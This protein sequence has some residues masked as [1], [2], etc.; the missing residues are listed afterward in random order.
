MKRSSKA[1]VL[2]ASA[3]LVSQAAQAAFT[4]NDLYLGFTSSSASSDYIIDLGQPGVVG[5]GA[6]S[7]VDLS[8][9]FSLSMFN[10][11]FHSGPSGVSMGVVGGQN[12]FPSSYDLF[13]TALRVGGA[14]DRAIAGSDLSSFSHSQASIANAEVAVTGNPFPTAGNGVLDDTKSWA[15]NIAP[16]LTAST[17]YGA[18]GINPNADIGASGVLYEDLW[19]A[20]PNSPYSYLGY[21]TLDLSGPNPSLSF[22]AVPEPTSFS[23][24]GAGLLALA[25]RRPLNRNNA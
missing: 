14:G 3:A 16:T 24:I 10:T 9:S 2:A 6:S 12:Q 13:A 21:L 1:T 8:G 5:V 7:P 17:F 15:A 23:L 25:V 18:S 11:A 22:T 19:K 4:A 20:T